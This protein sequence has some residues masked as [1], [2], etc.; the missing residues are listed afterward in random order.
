MYL[1]RIWIVCLFLSSSCRVFKGCLVLVWEIF[2]LHHC[3]QELLYRITAASR[4]GGLVCGECDSFSSGFT[5]SWSPFHSL[6]LQLSSFPSCLAGIFLNIEWWS[7]FNDRP[8]ARY[9]RCYMWIS[10]AIHV[11]FFFFSQTCRLHIVGI[12][13]LSSHFL[14]DCLSV[15]LP[16]FI[17]SFLTCF[18]S[19]VL[20]VKS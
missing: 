11:L 20:V 7:C 5:V 3:M 6:G 4:R 15:P 14:V 12:V 13:S 18:A 17:S 10:A 9:I 2:N 19:I 1:W 16:A 8:L